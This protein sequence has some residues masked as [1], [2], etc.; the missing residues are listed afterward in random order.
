MV[1]LVVA[2]RLAPFFSIICSV[3]VCHRI[4]V[5]RPFRQTVLTTVLAVVRP[6]YSFSFFSLYTRKNLEY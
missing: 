5:S 1:L 6:L 4:L 3:S 2:K